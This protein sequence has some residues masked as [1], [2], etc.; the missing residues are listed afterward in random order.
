MQTND[1]G[2]GYNSTLMR[3]NFQTMGYESS[4]LLDNMG[5]L[6]LVILALLIFAVTLLTILKYL[7]ARFA[8]IQKLYNKLH[9]KI[10]FNSFLRSI[11][12]GYLAFCLA[13]MISLEKAKDDAKQKAISSVIAAFLLSLP[14]FAVIFFRK[15]IHRFSEED[16]KLRYGSLYLNLKE[17]SLVAMGHT[18]LYFV[19]RLI[20]AAIIVFAGDYP[21][22]QNII[23]V[24]SSLALL[25][26]QFHVLPMSNKSSQ[27]MELF[28][29][30]TIMT[31]GCL[32]TP[33]SSD[34]FDL[35]TSDVS[36]N[37]GWIIVVMTLA[38]IG[39]N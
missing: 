16:F 15:Y 7:A 12:K 2:F 17:N 21:S 3:S 39:L 30:L 25:S 23:F 1:E 6:V 26:F 10:F 24:L 32:L 37:Y 33:F 20:Y 4:D 5:M 36:Y 9:Q 38:N 35:T 18:I 29:E 34:S 19:R 11:Q 22:L 31:I 14:I 8:L 28:N 27:Y 13:I